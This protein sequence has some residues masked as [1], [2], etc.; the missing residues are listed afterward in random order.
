MTGSIGVAILRPSI[1]VVADRAGSSIIA[2]EELPNYH[3]IF[4]SDTY[5]A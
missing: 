2:P 5:V 1:V 3:C 4:A